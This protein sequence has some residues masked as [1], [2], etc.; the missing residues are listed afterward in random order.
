MV[1]N[2]YS[3][4][5]RTIIEKPHHRNPIQSNEIAFRFRWFMSM[6]ILGVLLHIARAPCHMRT[7]INRQWS[8]FHLRVSGMASAA[9]GYSDI[10][11][12]IIL[13]L[14]NILVLT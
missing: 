4:V 3:K 8:R 2:G 7:V 6:M 9:F 12:V 5:L 14:R 13:I 10:H 1:T 11:M